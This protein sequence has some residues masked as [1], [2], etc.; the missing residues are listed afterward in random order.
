MKK[1]IL[2]RIGVSVIFALTVLLQPF[3]AAYAEKGIGTTEVSEGVTVKQN[4]NGSKTV[5]IEL[6]DEQIEST[7]TDNSAARLM[8][9]GS[10]ISSTSETV[11]TRINADF[12][13]DETLATIS[14][15]GTSI[16]FKPVI[17]TEHFAEEIPV[18]A[19]TDEPEQIQNPDVPATDSPTP[20]PV[21]TEEPG[22]TGSGGEPETPG[23]PEIQAV[24]AGTE[25]KEVSEEPQ[26][27]PRS[28][29]APET[30]ETPGPAPSVLPEQNA[31]TGTPS[32][33]MEP[34][35]SPVAAQ[36]VQTRTVIPETVVPELKREGY[37][38]GTFES[39][40]FEGVFEPETDVRLQ[41]KENGVKEDIIIGKYTGNH[42]FEYTID[43]NGLT[44]EQNGKEILLRDSGGAQKAV[45]AAPY[46][47]DAAGAYSEDIEVAF[48][49]N[50][51]S[52]YTLRYTAGSWLNESRAF[53]VVIDPSVYYDSVSE[54]TRGLEDNH[55]ANTSP[56]KVF[57]YNAPSFRVGNDTTAIYT[58]YVRCVIPDN[59][60]EE[61]QN[62]Y[63]QNATVNMY[64]KSGKSSGNT[65]SIHRAE[66][67]WSSQTITYN[68]APSYTGE[69]YDTKSING[70]GWVSWDVT[71]MFSEY[72]NV[73]D[74]KENCGFA[75]VSDTNDYG[76]YREFVS[77]DTPSYRMTFS[78]T[79]YVWDGDNTGV[80]AT[81]HGNG[82][83]SGTGYV[84]L[85]WNR[86]NGASGYYVGIFDGKDYEY[87]DVG[88]TTSFTTR[89][90]GL[91][92]ATAEINAGNAKL[93][94]GGGGTELPMI[95]AL[96]YAKNNPGSS[97][98]NDLNYYF[99]VVPHNAYGQAINPANFTTANCILPDTVPPNAPSAVTVNPSTWT[100]G[101]SLT[102]SWSGVTDYTNTTGG[103]VSNLGNGR[104]Q[105]MLDN[106][107]VWTDTDK[108]TASGSY[109]VSTSGLADGQHTIYIR[110]RDAA[111]NTGTPKGSVFYID[112]TPPA[113]PVLSAVP[114][115]WT[116][117][118]TV[119]LTW[120]AL[121]DLNNLTKVEYSI[122]SGSW[123]DTGRTDK[124]YSG[125]AVDISGLADGEHTLSVRGTDI[126]GNVGNAGTVKIY[127]DTAPP[128]AET[129]VAPD[130]WS[131]LDVLHIMWQNARD[132]H[133]GL[134]QIEYAVNENE[135]IAVWNKDSGV[136]DSTSP[137]PTPFDLL[138]LPDIEPVPA[139]PDLFALPGNPLAQMPE[140]G[141]IAEDISH[142]ADG[143]HEARL[144]LTDN[145][146][147]QQEYTHDF[148]RDIT[149][150]E[151]ELT[152]PMD[153]DI[154]NGMVEVWGSIN[155]L[156]LSEWTLT[157][158]GQ[159]GKEVELARGGENQDGAMLGILNAGAF[160]DKEEITI[161]LYAID[162][163]GNENEVTGVV[164]KVDKSA[165]PVT[166]SVRITSPATGTHITTN[167]ADVAY[168][169]EY[170]GT[171]DK[172]LMY[173]DGAFFAERA[174]SLPFAFDAIT[175]PE[176]S[177]HTVS[178]L[179]EDTDGNLHYSNGLSSYVVLTDAFDSE[180]FTQSKTNVTYAPA[181]ATLTD[182]AQDGE[183]ISV[184]GTSPKDILALRLTATEHMPYGTSIEYYFSTDD[185]LTWEPI[186]T[187]R[188]VALDEPAKEVMLKTVLH[189]NGT[190]SPTLLAWQLEGIIEMNP[191]RLYSDLT[192]GGKTF[193]ITQDAD[194]RKG[195]TPIENTLDETENSI[196]AKA[197]Y[198]DGVKIAEDY[199]YGAYAREE[200]S[201]HTITLLAEDDTGYLHASGMG[202]TELLLRD[203]PEKTGTVESGKLTSTQDI[204]A[205]RLDALT[206]GAK[207]AYYYSL[208]GA[209]WT[210]LPLNENTFLPKVTKELYLK[211]ELPQDATLRSWHLEGIYA[212]GKSVNI[213]LA[214]PPVNVT[215][216]NYGTY[217]EN[218]KLWK[219]ELSWEDV[220]ETDDTYTNAVVYD[221]YRNGTLI[222]SIP[223]EEGTRATDTDYLSGAGYEI[224]VR[225]VYGTVDAD[226]QT[227]TIY[228]HQSLLT[229]ART[230]DMQRGGLVEGVYHDLYEFKQGEYLDQ[231]Y[232]GN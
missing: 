143:G 57:T 165:K 130:S 102:V 229:A 164:V 161:T 140:S 139:L 166:G 109:T 6:T 158:A 185:G 14:K 169:K 38:G 113:A 220:N 135:Y 146:G 58:A 157:A 55:V 54:G 51:G 120:S 3:A 217:Y 184:A 153:G 68:N 144:R 186:T 216:A 47:T 211:A 228:N 127:K 168:E 222:A 206:D 59:I 196:T 79:Y 189:G 174:D 114:D 64:E 65:F 151:L 30:E 160:E 147:Q 34:Q 125:F 4:W 36:Q 90:R 56:D 93:H 15:D 71:R 27:Q 232:V 50:G 190:D 32:E 176:D 138:G 106:S 19:Q 69:A 200:R 105:Y 80:A 100:N 225:R 31:D 172:A 202:G 76:D 124:A 213:R 25:P 99:K 104:I 193:E 170:E 39:A 74:Q 8:E 171:Q 159:S 117:Q 182:P 223:K 97:Y 224:A 28:S 181:S 218:E 86:V 18:E 152:A 40:L 43:L 70:S 156:S 81:S 121:N 107:N 82:A 129:S 49:H 132:A 177:A 183:I 96:A 63:I 1:K 154:V 35:P 219:Y 163:A 126:A 227:L 11:D 92:P 133:S 155:D 23:E 192:R 94:L 162:E 180:E 195:I 141:D 33:L 73:M 204:Y 230:V 118:D 21:P 45:I 67:A 167:S 123:T 194:I 48:H 91:W 221:I 111:G 61:A 131:N 7:G 175:Y 226:A 203:N 13:K 108:N 198:E 197:M 205:I 112:R 26:E 77:A 188:D 83:G 145:L 199:D 17:E 178:I 10:A 122:D 136:T 173:I 75:I 110:G 78:M 60:K 207:G 12:E 5:T 116:N 148:Y 98:A 53:P 20:A 115:T 24:P 41:A 89:G 201:V 119:S 44:P 101:S 2:F 149:M 22:E 134:K 150:P 29:P 142:L 214:E 128:T 62:S 231:L 209:E 137:F 95:P 66:S 179:S 42:V 72:F 187:E 212:A 215:A 87:I 88:D 208:D 16:S 9:S 52:S 37:S 85:S 191:L 46:M 84:D 103:A 210:K